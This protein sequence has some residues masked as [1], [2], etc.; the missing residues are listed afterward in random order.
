MLK[1]FSELK[2]HHQFLYSLVIGLG[3][4]IFWRGVWD[5]WHYF[6]FPSNMLLSGGIAVLVGLIIM[7]SAHY[8]LS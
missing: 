1:K 8:K 6:V 7:Y 4:I 3:V 2:K 5:L